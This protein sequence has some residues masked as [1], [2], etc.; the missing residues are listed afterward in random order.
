MQCRLELLT[1]IP[2]NWVR[3]GSFVAILFEQSKSSILALPRL[4]DIVV[5]PV[6]Q[7]GN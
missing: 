7:M 4:K 1:A 5:I 3:V 2:T 6:P